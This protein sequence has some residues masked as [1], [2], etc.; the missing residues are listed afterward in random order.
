MSFDGG[1]VSEAIT[2]AYG[3]HADAYQRFEAGLEIGKGRRCSSVVCKPATLGVIGEH[4]LSDE[5]SSSST[6]TITGRKRA[7]SDAEED[8]A[9]G[10]EG[11]RRQGERGAD[12]QGDGKRGGPELELRVTV[13]EGKFHQV[14]KH[15]KHHYST[16]CNTTRASL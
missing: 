7:R 10:G 14:R 4:Y 9:D 6:T 8:V 12:R 11:R 15:C 5:S 2:A 3:I 13:M 16:P 1:V